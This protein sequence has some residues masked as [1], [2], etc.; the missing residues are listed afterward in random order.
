MKKTN[1]SKTIFK[2]LF[3]SF[4]ILHGNIVFLAFNILSNNQVVHIKELQFQKIGQSSILPK[5]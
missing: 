4:W 1:F 2:Q 5:G 3:Y